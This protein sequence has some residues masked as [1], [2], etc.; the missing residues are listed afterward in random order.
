MEESNIR[1]D[2][3]AHRFVVDVGAHSGYVEYQRKDGILAINHTIVPADIGGRGIAA[4]LVQATLEY[5]RN[6]GL[7]VQSNCSYARAYL[8]KHPEYADLMA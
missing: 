1:H 2:A 6:E 7:K 3:A 4:R 5:A 8:D